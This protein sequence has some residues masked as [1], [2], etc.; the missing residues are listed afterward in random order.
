MERAFARRKEY[1]IQK[2][3]SH[4]SFTFA[5]G[6]ENLFGFCEDYDKVVYGMRHKL[7][8]VRKSND[9]AIFKVEATAKGKV[10]LT[11]VDWEMPHVHPN[12]VKKFSLYKIIESIVLDAAFRMRQCSIAEIPTQTRN[13]DWRLDVRTALEKPRHVLIA[14]Q[15]DRSGNRGKNP[16]LFD[17]LS[18]TQV[19]VVLNDTTYP[20][21]DGIADFKKHIYVEYYKMFT[22]FARDYYG[23]DPLTVSNFVDILTYKEE[24][25]VFYFDVSKQSERVSQSVVDIKIRMRFAENV[26]ANVV[27][28]VLVISDRRLKSQSDGKKMNVIY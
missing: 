14:F 1:I 11:K 8:L 21:R 20:A 25:P 28:C 23:M 4:G 26:G 12:D 5:I 6:L 27:A 16:S 7:T 24:L 18:A 13:F 3:D 22:E 10:E 15:S 19:S 2:S 17:H 9:D